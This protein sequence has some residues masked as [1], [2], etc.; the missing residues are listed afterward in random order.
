[1]RRWCWLVVVAACGG[2]EE[3]L[4]IPDA[5]LLDAFTCSVIAQDCGSAMKCTLT[6]ADDTNLQP[7]CLPAGPS[8]IDAP[9]SR[10]GAF[11]EDDCVARGFC[12][13]AGV[14]PP[15]SGGSRYCR[16]L[17]SAD[18]QCPSGQKCAAQS[19]DGLTGFCVP[20]CTAFGACPNNMT[21]AEHR[22]NVSGFPSFLLD[23]RLPGGVAV[24]GA[25]QTDLNCVADA[26]CVGNLCRALCDQAHACAAGSCMMFG[27]AGVCL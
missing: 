10:S 13:F 17:C 8:A 14:L 5:N 11:G 3:D 21:C 26:V 25:C 20:T 15:T 12:T 7:A 23:C 2:H 19:G 27:D 4:P 6:G 22:T 1:M 24:G 18:P 9:C 16:T